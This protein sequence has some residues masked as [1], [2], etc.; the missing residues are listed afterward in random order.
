MHPRILLSSACALLAILVGCGPVHTTATGEL[1][2]EVESRSYRDGQEAW[3]ELQV[4]PPPVGRGPWQV[5]CESGPQPEFQISE[6]G[7][8]EV[9]RWKM[10]PGAAWFFPHDPAYRLT[11]KHEG[12]EDRHLDVFLQ[13]Q[14]GNAATWAIRVVMGSVRMF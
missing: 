13:T 10:P 6:N 9:I 8:F 7:R 11:L 3:L 12:T 1:G 4:P 14:G 2:R 5:V